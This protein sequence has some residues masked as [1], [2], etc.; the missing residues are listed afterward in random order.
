MVRSVGMDGEGDAFA[1]TKKLFN[2]FSS[3][4]ILLDQFGVLSR[5]PDCSRYKSTYKYCTHAG[6]LSY[7]MWDLSKRKE[8][9][10]QVAALCWAIWLC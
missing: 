5:T 2:T 4:V 8:I 9:F 1:S 3:V 7:W 6:G 10:V